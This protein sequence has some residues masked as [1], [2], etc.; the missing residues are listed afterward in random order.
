M[1]ENNI[2]TLRKRI[3]EQ[4]KIINFFQEKFQQQ[5]GNTLTLPSTWSKFLTIEDSEAP[6]GDKMGQEK[7]SKSSTNFSKDNKEF[8]ELNEEE[9]KEEYANF[10][11]A[12]YALNLPQKKMEDPK[13]NNFRIKSGKGQRGTIGGSYGRS[14]QRKAGGLSTTFSQSN[15]FHMVEK[16]NLS[17]YVNKVRAFFLKA[18]FEE[19]FKSCVS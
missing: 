11:Q 13:G 7:S 10:I 16:I 14:S 5:T 8:G 3:Q 6:I 17:G 1:N 2:E 15:P 4:N 18:I 9:N 19:F 12:F